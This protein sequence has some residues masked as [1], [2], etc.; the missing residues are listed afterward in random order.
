[1][2]STL[3]P[4]DKNLWFRNVFS[5]IPALALDSLIFVSIAFGGLLPIW[6]IIWGQI[7]TKWFFGVADTSF[8]YLSR[9][10]TSDKITFLDNLFS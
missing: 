5:D 4:K 10:I 8:I 6:S 1:M 3:V 2:F 7:L 9:A